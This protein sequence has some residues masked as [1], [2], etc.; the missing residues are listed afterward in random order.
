MVEISVPS[1]VD[2]DDPR[3]EVLTRA[4]GDIQKRFGEGSL[5]RLGE[6]QHMARGE[7]GYGRFNQQGH[8]AQ[9]QTANEELPAGESKVR[10]LVVPF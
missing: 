3:R 4:I 2:K 8:R 10:E 5:M 6:A 9:C 1:Y 7:R